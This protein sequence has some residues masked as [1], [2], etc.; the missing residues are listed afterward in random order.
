MARYG[1]SKVKQSPQAAIASSKGM[2]TSQ[3]AIGKGIFKRML[4][5]QK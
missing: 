1:K 5:K 2:S 3:S 4:G